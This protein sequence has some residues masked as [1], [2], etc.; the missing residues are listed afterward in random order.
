MQNLINKVIN[1]PSSIFTKDDVLILL[2]NEDVDTMI[3]HSA[4]YKYVEIVEVLGLR[5]QAIPNKIA[6]GNHEQLIKLARL[7]AQIVVEPYDPVILDNLQNLPH[8]ACAFRR[9]HEMLLVYNEY[10]DFTEALYEKWFSEAKE[11]LDIAIQNAVEGEDFCELAE[12]EGSIGADIE[13]GGVSVDIQMEFTNN[14][15]DR[16]AAGKPNISFSTFDLT[17]IFDKIKANFTD[18]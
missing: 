2:R 16:H 15:R 12:L 13:V 6:V 17:K 7:E 18:V 3:V 5:H 10:T 1:S 9:D 4:D 14:Q 11:S 8:L